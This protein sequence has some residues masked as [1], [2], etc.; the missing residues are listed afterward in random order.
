MGGRS[1]PLLPASLWYKLSLILACGGKAMSL[2][3]AQGLRDALLK[4]RDTYS[5]P[6]AEEAQS[7]NASLSTDQ[8]IKPEPEVVRLRADMPAPLLDFKLKPN[9][10][11]LISTQPA[12][13]KYIPPINYPAEEIETRW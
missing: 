6:T 1:V 3:H 4:L 8:P 10:A 7:F 2:A 13:K 9:R 5:P 12:I 11:P